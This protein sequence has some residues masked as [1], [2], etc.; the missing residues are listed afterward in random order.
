MSMDKFVSTEESLA[1]PDWTMPQHIV[2]ALNGAL[3]DER[4]DAKSD[5]EVAKRALTRAIL[6]E[7]FKNCGTGAGGF[8]PGNSC[9]KEEGGGGD[10][11][12]TK[13]IGSRV[14]DPS[15]AQARLE[16]ITEHFRGMSDA[17]FAKAAEKMLV[18]GGMAKAD[19]KEFLKNLNR[20]SSTTDRS[21]EKM[22]EKD[23]AADEARIASGDP[24]RRVTEWSEQDQADASSGAVHGTVAALALYREVTGESLSE[25]MPTRTGDE[26]LRLTAMAQNTSVGGLFVLADKDRNGDWQFR[27]E[28]RMNTRSVAAIPYEERR[29]QQAFGREPRWKAVARG[30]AGSSHSVGDAI[31]AIGD[32]E[33]RTDAGRVSELG[34]AG[35]RAALSRMTSSVYGRSALQSSYVM[36]HELGHWRHYQEVVRST[37]NLSAAKD[38]V[39]RHRAALGAWKVAS[40][41]AIGPGRAGVSQ[42]ARTSPK[43]FVA[44]VFAGLAL[45]M[46]FDEGVM[47]SYE[48]LAG[49][50]VRRRS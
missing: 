40:N 25:V 38:P 42:Y 14:T 48:G 6:A 2:D 8:Q 47:K 46:R 43:E 16:S 28:I 11:K 35:D 18:S 23:R 10:I 13:N 45:G 44:E 3:G 31:I 49:P 33:G 21:M 36:L 32:T 37:V 24:V 22:T 41:L 30:G 5:S 17:A 4:S 9:G 19:A 1:P 39:E 29:A 27:P 20:A 34:Y 7:V 12:D 15:E 26:P 50:K